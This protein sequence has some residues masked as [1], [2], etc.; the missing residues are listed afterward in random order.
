MSAPEESAIQT[1]ED[2]IEWLS[3]QVTDHTPG[4]RR[5]DSELPEPFWA[6]ADKVAG[7]NEVTAED[8]IAATDLFETWQ[9]D[10]NEADASE[11]YLPE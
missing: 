2:A 3:A 11:E 4:T 10:L 7:Q 9:N 6:L 5:T 1:E 8:A